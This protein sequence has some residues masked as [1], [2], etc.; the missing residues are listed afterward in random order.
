M[1]NEIQE[2]IGDVVEAYVGPR[3]K[4]QRSEG[5]LL[6][7]GADLQAAYDALD[8]QKRFELGA[9]LL[10]LFN[11]LLSFF[12]D[13]KS[14]VKR[15][16]VFAPIVLMLL[17]SA[18][19]ITPKE[20]GAADLNLNTKNNQPTA[21]VDPTRVSEDSM[22]REAIKLFGE[23]G[24][25][26]SDRDLAV[27]ATPTPTPTPIP[28]NEQAQPPQEQSP[29]PE[30]KVITAVVKPNSN[31][32]SDHNI[33]SRIVARLTQERVTVIGK[34]EYSSGYDWY[35]IRT[36]EEEGFVR[37]DL[38]T[39][40]DPTVAVPVLETHSA[41]IPTPKPP[42]VRESQ[43]TKEVSVTYITPA[44]NT[45]T[46]SNPFTQEG[47]MAPGPVITN[48]QKFKVLTGKGP[49]YEIVFDGNRVWI[50]AT[51]DT[52][53]EKGTEKVVVQ[54][55][56]PVVTN[57]ETAPTS[58]GTHFGGIYTGRVWYIPEVELNLSEG[59]HNK[60]VAWGPDT[61]TITPVTGWVAE[62]SEVTVYQNEGNLIFNVGA[63]DQNNDGS[64]SVL[65]NR[66]N[67]SYVVYIY[68]RDDAD[69]DTATNTKLPYHPSMVSAGERVGVNG[70]RL[71]LFVSR[72]KESGV[73]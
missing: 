57:P 28:T 19:D 24:A 13:S 72:Q 29:S 58:T 52:V 34:I 41:P 39:F 49:W 65:G 44:I 47:R 67:S 70:N 50:L 35:K 23:T 21:Q 60:R 46:Y 18:C 33:T 31:L 15:F 62:A 63:V 1:L 59:G 66:L 27:A 42:T 3:P 32:R 16:P 14:L 37:E 2:K 54:A 8:Y 4:P 22:L 61:A 68:I 43:T 6:E 40:D 55:S 71:L 9:D 64:Y 38:L 53:I 56:G 11:R 45:I 69:N 51:Q 17:L 73:K 30:A 5:G 12:P 7:F 36:F 26:Q 25:E 10:L 20:A 48:P